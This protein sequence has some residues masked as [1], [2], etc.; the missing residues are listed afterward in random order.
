MTANFLLEN[1]IP[2][3]CSVLRE[4]NHVLLNSPTIFNNDS[5][6]KYQLS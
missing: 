5:F 3:F 6:L 4:S 1:E 2:K